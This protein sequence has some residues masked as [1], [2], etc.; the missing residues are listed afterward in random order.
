MLSLSLIS[1]SPEERGKGRRWGGVSGEAIDGRW[2]ETVMGEGCSEVG[3]GAGGWWGS[4]GSILFLLFL[5][6]HSLFLNEFWFDYVCFGGG[7]VHHDYL[8]MFI[9]EMLLVVGLYITLLI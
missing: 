4:K 8:I 9:L 1:L 7:S 5:Q 3:A 2:W 6:S